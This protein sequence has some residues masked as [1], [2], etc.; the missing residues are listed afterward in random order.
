MGF[1]LFHHKK[2][3]C[4]LPIYKDFRAIVVFDFNDIF[5][6]YKFKLTSNTTGIKSMGYQNSM[7]QNYQ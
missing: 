1:S 4:K 6:W 2:K 5:T 3:E 7:T